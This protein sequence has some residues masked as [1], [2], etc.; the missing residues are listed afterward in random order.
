MAAAHVDAWWPAPSRGA[1]LLAVKFE[2]RIPEGT[3]PGD[4]LYVALPTGE[5]VK[6]VVPPNAAVGSV[7]TCSALTSGTL[8]GN[9]DE[10]GERVGRQP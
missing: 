5:E 6:V 3:A 10:N 7:L 2:L 8:A 1:Q 4:T 9:D